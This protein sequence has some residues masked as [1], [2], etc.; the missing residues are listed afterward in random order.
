MTPFHNLADHLEARGIEAEAVTDAKG[1]A[2]A[3]RL[4]GDGR[5]KTISTLSG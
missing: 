1:Q 4:K 3:V 5:R 2:V